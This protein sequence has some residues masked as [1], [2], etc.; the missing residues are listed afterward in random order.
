MVFVDL[1]G[2]FIFLINFKNNLIENV[3]IDVGDLRWIF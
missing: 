1:V 3:Y 2:I